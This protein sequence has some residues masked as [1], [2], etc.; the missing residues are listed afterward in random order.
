MLIRKLVDESLNFHWLLAALII[1]SLLAGCATEPVSEKQQHGIN[2]SDEIPVIAQAVYRDGTDF[3]FKLRHGKQGLY[4]GAYLSAAKVVNAE[5]QSRQFSAPS[6]AAIDYYQSTP[7]TALPNEASK[8][9]VLAIDQWYQLRD[10]LFES[11]IPRDKTGLVMNFEYEDYFLFYD[12]Q[13]N[14][15]ATRLVDKP[16]DYQ[17]K[18]YLHFEKFVSDAARVLKGF[19]LR[20]GITAEEF[21]FNTGDVGLYSLPF[22]YVNT[23]ERQLAF[24]RN[25]PLQPV[26]LGAFPGMKSGQT[27]VHV[28]RSH[29]GGVYTRPVSSLFRLVTAITDT[30]AT[31]ASFEWATALSEQ[32][33]P[34]LSSAAP[35]NL[36]QWESDL[37]RLTAHDQSSGS[38]DFL[39][40]GEAFFTRFIDTVS[41]AEKTVHLQTYIFDND[42]YAMQ[43]ADLLKH[44]SKEGVQVKVLLDGLGTITAGMADSPS[45]PESHVAPVSISQYL[46]NK[47]KVNVRQKENPWLTSDH[48][49]SII[50]DQEIAFVG[51]MNIGREYRYDW[52]DLML[53]LQGP[54]VDLIEKEF[55][56]AWSHA[57][58]LGDLGYIISKSR[59]L[60]ETGT[61]NNSAR[62]RVLLTKPGNYEIYTTQLEAIRRAKRYIYI[63]NAYITNDRVLRELVK[64]RRRGVDVRVITPIETDHKTITKSNVL[65]VNVMLKNGIRVYIYPGF[66]HVKAAIYDGWVCVGSANFDRLSLRVNRELNIASSDPEVAQQL[67]EKLFQPDFENSPEL[68]EPLPEHWIDRLAEIIGDYIY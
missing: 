43:I 16:G 65:A 10:E 32:P 33:V 15:Q 60:A 6:L 36:Q 20:Q 30:A 56:K 46:E 35:M 18:G 8:I 5:Q 28:L 67:L 49:K 61:V 25:V 12:H 17:V 2:R 22:L 45:L 24:F 62:L 58:P 29:V 3:F 34:P 48:V 40:D 31:T 41:A 37:E 38:I 7:W 26:A 23:H 21:I 19:M 39:V 68:T 11:V 52:H 63:Q 50:I 42:D 1:F 54:V 4:A 9:P 44:R 47:S 27:L 57:G 14:F 53:E 13:E 59:R 64:A 51:G 55:L 66:S